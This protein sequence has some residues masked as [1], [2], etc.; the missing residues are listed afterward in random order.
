MSTN[1]RA[2]LLQN[3]R[4]F[5]EEPELLQRELNNMYLDV[6]AAVNSRDIAVYTS[7]SGPNGQKFFIGS[8]VPLSDVIRVCFFI[9][10]ILNGATTLAHGITI[11]PTTRFTR[12]YGT[13]S[14]PSTQFIPIPYINVAAP[15]DS[16]QL[17]VNTT[18]IVLTTTTAN[19]TSYS[20][21]IVLEYIT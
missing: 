18:N 16:V 12:I 7:V 14:N 4:F 15:A 3:T 11:I 9:P 19:Y 5:P 8:S 1:S 20:A 21:V 2:P 6:A 17:D 10:S 13:G